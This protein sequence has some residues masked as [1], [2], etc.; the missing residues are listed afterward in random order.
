MGVVRTTFAMTAACIVR[1]HQFLRLGLTDPFAQHSSG[2]LNGISRSNTPSGIASPGPL[3]VTSPSPGSPPAATQP[4]RLLQ[5][6]TQQHALNQSLLA[7][8]HLLDEALASRPNTGR[9]TAASLLSPRPALLDSL[10]SAHMGNYQ[11]ILSLL[12]CVEGGKAVKALVDSVIESCDQVV[13]LREEIISYRIKA[14]L[15]LDEGARQTALDKAAQALEKYF[16]LIAFAAFVEDS[17]GLNG[18]FS[19]WLKARSEIWK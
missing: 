12:G 18:R 9:T 10:R 4:S 17:D 1:R 5:S 11:V 14:S 7:L 8:T 6:Y 13:N 15:E 3:G 2:P 16:F 19:S